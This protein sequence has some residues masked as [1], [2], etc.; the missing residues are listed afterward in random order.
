MEQ[1]IGTK[2]QVVGAVED[3]DV[4]LHEHVFSSPTLLLM[5]NERFGLSQAYKELSDVLVNIPMQPETVSSLNVA[6]AGTVLLYAAS[7]QRDA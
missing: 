1:E 7:L 2:V 6:C 3:G 5:G 4:S